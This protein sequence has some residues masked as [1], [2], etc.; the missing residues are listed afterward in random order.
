MS[1]RSASWQVL[2]AV[3]VADVPVIALLTGLDDAVTALPSRGNT[4][5]RLGSKGI[6]YW[7]A[8]VRR[9]RTGVDRQ[10]FTAYT[11]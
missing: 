10:A 3:A 5:V 11:A 9:R 8:G 2:V 4:S 7:D 6:G 1:R